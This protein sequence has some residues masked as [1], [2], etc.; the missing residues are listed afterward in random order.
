MDVNRWLR[1]IA[2]AFVL[3]TLLLGYYASAKWFLFTGFV[4]V[5]LIQSAF[6]TWCPMMAVLQKL[7]VRS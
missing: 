4:A 3:A 2:G 7:G 1:L 5:N 6:T